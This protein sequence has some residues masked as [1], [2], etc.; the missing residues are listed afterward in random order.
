MLRNWSQSQKKYKGKIKKA[1]A[2]KIKFN[3]RVEAGGEMSNMQGVK[4]PQKRARKGSFKQGKKDAGKLL[5]VAYKASNI[6][7]S[8]LADWGA[9][10]RNSVYVCHGTAYPIPDV[11]VNKVKTS[12]VVQ[13]TTGASG[14]LASIQLRLNDASDPFAAAGSAQPRFYDQLA[15]LYANHTVYGCKVMIKVLKNTGNGTTSTTRVIFIP[16]RNTTIPISSAFTDGNELP[17]NMRFDS[18]TGSNTYNAGLP[19][20]EAKEKSRYIDIGSFWGKDRKQVLTEEGFTGIAGAAPTYQVYGYI[21]VQE[22]EATNTAS[23]YIE[24]TVTQYVAWSNV[25][26]VGIS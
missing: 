12:S 18:S 20:I 23:V 2:P 17:M 13:M 5:C 10:G 16:S 3:F 24:V 7:K 4:S 25:I 22:L 21:A 15:A 14:A 19:M 1:E 6:P 26:Q 8:K 9:G 11:L